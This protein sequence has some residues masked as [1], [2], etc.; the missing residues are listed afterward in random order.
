MTTLATSEEARAEIELNDGHGN[1]SDI[2]RLQDQI[3]MILVRK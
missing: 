2:G 1:S 3:N